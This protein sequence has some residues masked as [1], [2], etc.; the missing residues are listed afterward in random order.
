LARADYEGA[1]SLATECE[2][3][4]RP[5]G[6]PECLGWALFLHAAVAWRQGNLPGMKAVLAEGLRCFQD[7]GHLWGLSIGI[8]FAAN[9][10]G[11]RGDDKQMV[12][13]LSASEAVR[14]SVGAAVLPFVKPWLD[15]ALR[16][17]KA[18]LD[19][20][21]FEHAWRTGAALTPSAAT[22]IAMETAAT[23]EHGIVSTTL[24]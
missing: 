22:A 15:E 21:T 23:S 20:A 10:A 1:A 8:F 3:L 6:D 18:T 9:L 4:L 19:S 7:L 13:L 2:A 16:E 14:D 17:A 5:A 12:V 24:T 11:A